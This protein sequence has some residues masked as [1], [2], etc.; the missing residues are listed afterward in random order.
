MDFHAGMEM[1]PRITKATNVRNE[2]PATDRI[3]TV[4]SPAFSKY[5]PKPQATPANTA[6]RRGVRI[7]SSLWL[8]SS[9]ARE[10][11]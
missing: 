8:S 11:R 6:Y 2:N 9:T 1:R 3:P 4:L 10:P 5:P 7:G